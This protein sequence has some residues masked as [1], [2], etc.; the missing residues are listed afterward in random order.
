MVGTAACN[1]PRVKVL[2]HRHGDLAGREQVDHLGPG[3]VVLHHIRQ[4]RL[5]RAKAGS[6]SAKAFTPAL[7]PA[8]ITTIGPA[9]VVIPGSDT[10][11]ARSSR[12]RSAQEVIGGSPWRCHRRCPMRPMV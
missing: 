4:D 8:I 10:D 5:D 9:V 6:S 2:R 12:H 11:A 7:S 3:V 1:W